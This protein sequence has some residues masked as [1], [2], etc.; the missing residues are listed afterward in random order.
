MQIEAPA[1][2]RNAILVTGTDT[3]I[4]K[5]TVACGLAAALAARG[6]RVAVC[7]PVETGCD[8]L[9]SGTAGSSDAER[10]RY[11]SGCPEPFDVVCPYRFRQPLAPSIAG[12]F[13]D[14]SVDLDDLRER[15]D[16]LRSRYD[17]TLIEGAGGLLVPVAG[18]I[19]FAD[20][21]VR[22]DTPV[23]VVVGN[24]LGA[25]NHAQLTIRWGQTAGVEIAGYVLNALAPRE[26]VAAATNARALTELIGPPL[27]IF[28]WL[29]EVRETPD[30]RRRLAQVTEDVIEIERLLART[31]RTA[32]SG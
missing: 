7:K 15:I 31:R 3:G 16:R 32:S 26:D 13:E 10:L 20:L 25:L 14:R 6:L 17:L 22:W 28:P 30:D 1:G 9:P 23:L 24:K 19:T 12:R 29:D 21:A 8:P 11:F 18:K 5:T 4:G 27:G 2:M